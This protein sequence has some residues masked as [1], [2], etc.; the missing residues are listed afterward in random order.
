[1]VI[2]RSQIPHDQDQLEEVL[3]KLSLP[4]HAKQASS[5]SNSSSQTLYDQYPHYLENSKVQ[6]I[7]MF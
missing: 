2:A 7:W 4:K 5:F 6:E 1:M 3:W